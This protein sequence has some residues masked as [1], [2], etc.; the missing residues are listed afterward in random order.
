MPIEKRTRVEIFLPL[1]SD[2]SNYQIILDWLVEEMAH[3]RGGATLTTP[4]A[5]LYASSTQISVIEDAIR[6]LFCD[7]ELD[8]ERPEDH[9]EIVAFLEEAKSFLMKTLKE[10]EIWIIFYPI[11]RIVS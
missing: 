3:T 8:S 9:S 4:F 11:S 1:R 7:F 6:I 5:G 10:E 2:L